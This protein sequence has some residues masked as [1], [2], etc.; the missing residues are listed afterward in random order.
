MTC[1]AFRKDMN[2]DFLFDR[3]VCDPSWHCLPLESTLPH[4][5]F[6]TRV[7]MM[8]YIAGALKP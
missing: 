1:E 3:R 2:S 4:V 6:S 7:K 8:H 5:I